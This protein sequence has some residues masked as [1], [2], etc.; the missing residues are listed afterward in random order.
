MKP[1][2]M[3]IALACVAVFSICSAL[4]QL[5][6]LAAI[7]VSPPVGFGMRIFAQSI[8]FIPILLLLLWVGKGWNLRALTLFLFCFAIF[9]AHFPSPFFDY[10]W[11]VFLIEA[12]FVFLVSSLFWA[13][14]EWHRFYPWPMRLLLFKIMFCMGV[15]KFMHGMPEWR[16]GLAMK[17]FWANQPMPGFLAWYGAQLPDWAQRAMTAYTF[18]VE[19]PGPFLIFMGFKPRRIYF[20]VNLLLQLGIFLSGNY[21]FFN[22]LAVVVSLALLDHKIP[23]QASSVLPRTVTTLSMVILLGWLYCSSWYVYRTLFPGEKYLHETSWIFMT[24]RE[25]QEL[26]SPVRA[27]LQIYGAAKASN[28]YALFGMIPKYRMEVAIEAGQEATALQRLK[29]RV[30]PDETTEAPVSYAPHHWRLDHQ[31]YY[32]SFRIRAPEMQKQHSFFLGTPWIHGFLREVLRGNRA[33]L[34]LLST[35]TD[36]GSPF[37]FVHF[38]YTYFDFTN[39]EERLKTNAYWKTIPARSGKFF[40]KLMS[41]ESLHELP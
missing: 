8:L 30:R 20:F 38:R 26:S 15:V 9:Y 23:A 11:D 18:L 16:T 22:I 39:Q 3:A 33:V 5:S 34:K 24:N 13:R 36:T 35:T 41:L 37:K 10:I 19:I 12:I 25:Q 40:E 17:F 7:A 27:A 4:P 14:T 1:I 21:G 29:F 31:M 28:P 32:E 2:T 6:G